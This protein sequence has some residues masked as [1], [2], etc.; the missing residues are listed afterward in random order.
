MAL[1]YS[2]IRVVVTRLDVAEEE[3]HPNLS[4]GGHVG[5]QYPQSPAYIAVDIIMAR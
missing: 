3:G 2:Q 4:E 5:L 1:G